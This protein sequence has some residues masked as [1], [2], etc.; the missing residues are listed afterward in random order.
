ME[1]ALTFTETDEEDVEQDAAEE[2]EDRHLPSAG[3]PHKQAQE[4]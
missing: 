4:K 1:V 2:G 3:D